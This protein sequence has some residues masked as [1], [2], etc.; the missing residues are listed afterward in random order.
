MRRYSLVVGIVV[1]SIFCCVMVGMAADTVIEKKIENVVF[2]KDKNG[3]QYARIIVQDQGTLNGVTYNKSASV[4]AFGDQVAS[5]KSLK[6]GQT[7]KAIVAE[8]TFRGGTSYQL[9]KVLK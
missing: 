6:K 2:K 1:L 4:M 3:Q 7:L 9:L 8:N 5:A